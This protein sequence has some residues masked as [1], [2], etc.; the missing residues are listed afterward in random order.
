MSQ[1]SKG[2][3]RQKEVK[4]RKAKKKKKCFSLI[5]SRV[6]DLHDLSLEDIKRL[7]QAGLTWKL[8]L[9]YY[10]P[11]KEQKVCVVLVSSQLAILLFSSSQTRIKMS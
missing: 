11:G 8:I 9:L 6:L 2:L 4:R 7:R 3:E 1:S 10:C 5:E